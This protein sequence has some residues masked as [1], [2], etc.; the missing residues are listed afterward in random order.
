MYDEYFLLNSYFP[1]LYPKDINP[2]AP[3][4]EYNPDKAREL[5]KEAGWQVGSD[6]ILTKDGQPF[7][8]SIL[9]Y[10]SSDMR[11]LNIYMEDLKSVGI[12]VSAEIVSEST[13]T[14]RVDNH[15]FDMIW[16]AWGDSRLRDPEAEWSS[17]TA[18]DI[19]T[20][21]ICGFKD[22]EVDKLIDEQK[23]EMDLGKRNEILKQ[24]DARLMA[25]CPY[26]LMWQTQSTKL[27]Y[28][29]RFGTPPYVLAK[30]GDESD[31]YVYWWYDQAKE[32]ALEDAMQKGVALPALPPKVQYPQ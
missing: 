2:N 26:V 27:L 5:L 3:T 4:I 21:N 23:T 8:I 22:A 13:Y 25:L 29:N 14:K 32:S 6:G 20:E 11:H 30:Y 24:I 16:Q 28:W 31:A 12:N 10:E 19:A 15:E 7:T 17:K 1:A 9:H 18:D